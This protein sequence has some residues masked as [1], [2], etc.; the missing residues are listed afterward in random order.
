MFQYTVETKRTC[1]G[2][3]LGQIGHIA[4]FQEKKTHREKLIV[5]LGIL[6]DFY[7]TSTYAAAT[8]VPVSFFF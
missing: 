6:R 7:V 8:Q 5:S 3:L 1:D 4:I 2:H